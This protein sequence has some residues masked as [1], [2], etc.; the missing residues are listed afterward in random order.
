MGS[1]DRL[2]LA[3]EIVEKV[4]E[5]L[6]HSGVDRVKHGRIVLREDAN[7]L[8]SLVNRWGTVDEC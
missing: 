7:A 1:A 8:Y 5:T 4:K 3:S 6:A 2:A